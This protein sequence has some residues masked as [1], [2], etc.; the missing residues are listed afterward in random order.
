MQA[1]QLLAALA[2]GEAVSGAQLADRAGVTRAAIWKQVEAPRARGVPVEPLG[3]AGC[4]LR[5][6]GQLRAASRIRAAV[7]R[8][9]AWGRGAV[10]VHWELDSTSSER[11]RRRGEVA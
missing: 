4:R 9:C 8:G 7:P 2:S 3:A 1:R 10:E 11:E 5:W 6:P